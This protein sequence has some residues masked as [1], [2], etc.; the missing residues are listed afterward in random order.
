MFDTGEKHDFKGLEAEHY[1][2]GSGLPDADLTRAVG[3]PCLRLLFE[4]DA[5][6]ACAVGVGWASNGS[7]VDR[8]SDIFE[9]DAE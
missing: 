6:L 9:F 2:G 7:V 3:G 5:D 1:D 8:M 4:F